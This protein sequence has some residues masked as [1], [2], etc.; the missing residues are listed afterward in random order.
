MSRERFVSGSRV[1]GEKVRPQPA[2]ALRLD[3]TADAFLATDPAEAVVQSMTLCIGAFLGEL[4]VRSA[5]GTWTYHDGMP[6]VLTREGILCFPFNR[7]ATV[8]PE[9]RSTVS[10][11]ST[12]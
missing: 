6:P 10:A 11:T 12:R 9:A 7:S 8:L 1:E 5:G 3:A 4:L 2:A